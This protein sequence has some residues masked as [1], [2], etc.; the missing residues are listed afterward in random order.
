M[1]SGCNVCNSRIQKFSLFLSLILFPTWIVVNDINF[2]STKVI[3]WVSRRHKGQ[4]RL[5]RKVLKDALARESTLCDELY[6]I[7][8]YTSPWSRFELTTSVV[9]CTDCI[10]SGKSNYHMITTTTD[11]NMF[12]EI[13]FYNLIQDDTY[14]SS[15]LD[16][17]VSVSFPIDFKALA[18]NLLQRPNINI[19][20]IIM[21]Y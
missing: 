18:F 6:H 16:N 4:E 13:V 5:F 21:I 3:Q 17:P 19:Y 10:G 20:S 2:G 15:R 9:T 14:N 12:F 7:M 8:L 11:P 1:P